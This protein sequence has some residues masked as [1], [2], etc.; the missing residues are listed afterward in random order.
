[1]FS[2]TSSQPAIWSPAP[3][4][5]V[6]AVAAAAPAA[7]V[8]ALSRDAQTGSDPSSG[9]DPSA[10]ARMA[11]AGGPAPERPGERIGERTGE[12]SA[13]P[14]AD[15]A[16][17][18]PRESPD[19]TDE[20][21]A[22]EQAQAAQEPDAQERLAEEKA[23]QQR[24]QDVISNVWKASAA[25]VDLALSREAPVGEAEPG[26]QAAQAAQAGS[27]A[28]GSHAAAFT[29]LPADSQPRGRVAAA[30]DDM[31][32]SAELADLRASQ[33]VVG[34]DEQGHSSLAPLEAGSLISRRV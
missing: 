10:A 6:A 33:E 8:R 13:S 2:I 32:E 15:A 19:G 21:P 26:T 27:S 17:L 25:V 22:A 16:P 14:T 24:L 30:N 23:I 28:Q 34:Y 29:G 9:R 3:S 11:R 31:A 1:M 5:V 7:P 12:R 20:Q 4:P 18:L